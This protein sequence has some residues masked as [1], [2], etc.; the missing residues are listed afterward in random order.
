MSMNHSS[1]INV[2]RKRDLP[3]W[4]TVRYRVINCKDGKKFPFFSVTEIRITVCR[5]TVTSYCVMATSCRTYLH[6]SF[7]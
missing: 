7:P 3:A 2:N 6:V 1:D 5:V 4:S